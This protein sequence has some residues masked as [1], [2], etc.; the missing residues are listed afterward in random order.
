MNDL[1]R[2]RAFHSGSVEQRAVGASVNQP[3]LI[4]FGIQTEI[5]M[6]AGHRFILNKVP[7]PVIE[8]DALPADEQVIED[9][10]H[11]LIFSTRPGNQVCQ[12]LG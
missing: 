9:G 8:T 3:G 6:V 7:V 4:V 12:R 5:G 10:H 1:C 2:Y 11:V